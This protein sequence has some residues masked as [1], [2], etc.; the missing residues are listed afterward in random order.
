MVLSNPLHPRDHT[1]NGASSIR[2]SFASSEG[3]HDQAG[4]PR[5]LGNYDL[6]DYSS[7]RGNSTPSRGPL[8]LG[9]HNDTS[10]VNPFPRS[11]PKVWILV[12][13]CLCHADRSYLSHVSWEKRRSR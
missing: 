13:N 4:F 11:I 10:S 7:S 8:P 5:L 9:R 2:V 1:L 3:T 12:A 6:G